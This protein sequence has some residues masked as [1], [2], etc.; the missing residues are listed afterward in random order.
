MALARR[1]KDEKMRQPM[2]ISVQIPTQTQEKDTQKE[3][4]VKEK[5][6][7]QDFESTDTAV[8]VKPTKWYMGEYANS[9]DDETDRFFFAY[10]T[11]KKWRVE[12]DMPIKQVKVDLLSFSLEHPI[13]KFIV[14]RTRTSVDEDA[15]LALASGLDDYLSKRFVEAVVRQRRAQML[16]HSQS[17]SQAHEGDDHS[18]L[19]PAEHQPP[20]KEWKRERL[21]ALQ[22][23]IPKYHIQPNTVPKKAPVAISEKSGTMEDLLTYVSGAL[24][25][26]WRKVAHYLGVHR[27]RVQAI[28]RN[29][30]VGERDETEAKYD[31]LLTWLK[32]APKSADKMAILSSALEHSDRIDLAETVKTWGH[33]GEQNGFRSPSGSARSFRSPAANRG[34]QTTAVH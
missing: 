7:M 27:A 3:K 16:A 11:G 31:M 34:P 5:K 10:Q 19:T 23:N 22:I 18:S 13:E 24:G 14:L 26:E 15:A 8:S 32:G 20:E 9:E 2:K 30:H 21:C 6:R 17:H 1:L 25:E 4:Q 12:T 33:Q 28:I 29:V